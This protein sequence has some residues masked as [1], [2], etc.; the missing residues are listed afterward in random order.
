M[1]CLVAAAHLL[2]CET[3]PKKEDVRDPWMEAA[4]EQV[5][6]VLN[7]SNGWQKRPGRKDT[8]LER[9]FGSAGRVSEGFVWTLR[10]VEAAEQLHNLKTATN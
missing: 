8:R 2:P 5:T 6:K 10:A 1:G 3:K 4:C 7:L 9:C